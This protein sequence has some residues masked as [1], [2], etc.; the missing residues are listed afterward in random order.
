MPQ[1]LTR[2]LVLPL[3]V[4]LRHG[5]QGEREI[6]S[7]IEFLDLL[8][9][10]HVK[11]RTL[12]E[13]V[14]VMLSS[15]W[16]GPLSESVSKES[17]GVVVEDDHFLGRLGKAIGS[18][19]TVGQCVGLVGWVAGFVERGLNALEGVEG[20]GEGEMD[21]DVIMGGMEECVGMRFGLG[22]RIVC[23]V[24]ACLNFE[25]VSSDEGIE[26]LGGV[27]G[28]VDCMAGELVR[29]LSLFER[30][31]RELEHGLCAL[32]RMKYVL[33]R[34]R[35][36]LGEGVVEDGYGGALEGLMHL[37]DRD[38]KVEE[39]DDG[40]GEES[41]L[42][43][44]VFE[45]VSRL[46]FGIVFSLICYFFVGPDSVPSYFYEKKTTRPFYLDLR[47]GARREGKS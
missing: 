16:E 35:F 27:R 25:M 24:L 10:C 41:P 46:F 36:V 1:I 8:L 26:K 29:R 39:D 22:A 40:E 44:L 3:D 11:T 38:R 4:H 19:G 13:L 15:I 21:V 23:V 2:V 33:D 20:K 42:P 47:K 37:L 14:G 34:D 32:L 7:Y 5:M 28:R 45:L 30:M 31:E 6:G 18:F 17:R 12:D 9:E 43:E